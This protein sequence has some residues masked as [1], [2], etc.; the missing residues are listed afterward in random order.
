M[1]GPRK[2]WQPLSNSGEMKNRN[3]YAVVLSLEIIKKERA[4]YARTI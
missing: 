3:L 1:F 2:I 4:N